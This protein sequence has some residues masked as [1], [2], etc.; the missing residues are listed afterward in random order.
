MCV[1]SYIMDSSVFYR[2]CLSIVFEHML[3]VYQLCITIDVCFDFFVECYSSVGLHVFKS[4]RNCLQVF[5]WKLNCGCVL[6]RVSIVLLNVLLMDHH[7]FSKACYMWLLTC[8]W[9]FSDWCV[10]WCLAVYQVCLK[11]C[12]GC[13]VFRCCLHVARLFFLLMCFNCF[14][15]VYTCVVCVSVCCV[16]VCCVFNASRFIFW[17]YVNRLSIVYKVC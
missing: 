14:P 3:F 8:F 7:V 11:S 9:A 4:F 13:C 15:V 17:M 2:A 6:K 1:V 10:W 5:F 16:F 12:C